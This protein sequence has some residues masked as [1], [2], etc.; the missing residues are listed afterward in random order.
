MNKTLVI[1]VVVALVCGLGLGWLLHSVQPVPVKNKYGA[2]IGYLSSGGQQLTFNAFDSIAQDL[3]AV[4]APLAGM[5]TATTLSLQL[6]TVSSG[7]VPS[8]GVT[9][10]ATTSAALGDFVYVVANTPTSGVTYSGTVSVASTTAPTF[11]ISVQYASGTAGGVSIVPP[12]STFQLYILPK[13]S[14]LAPAALL[15]STSTTT[16]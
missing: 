15:T 7:T 9:T 16:N 14:F 3:K 10:V 5:L 6:P 4:R 11:T 8:G 12:A 2:V 13:A 1:A